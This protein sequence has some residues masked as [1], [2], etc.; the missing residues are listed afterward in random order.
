MI[1]F[2]LNIQENFMRLII[3]DEF[4]FEL[5]LHDSQWITFPIQSCLLLYSFRAVLLNLLFIFFFHIDFCINVIV[6]YFVVLCCYSKRFSFSFEVCPVGWDCKIYRL[7]LCRGVGPHP[8]ECP[9]Y[10]TKQSDGEAQVMLELWGMQ[11]TPSLPSLPGLLWFGVVA[12]D[13]IQSMGQI[14]LNY[15]LMLN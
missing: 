5:L 10:D 9:R 13:R 6:P 4:C 11:S 7:H 3:Q 1:S 15:V 2:Y 14:E 12:P 8:N